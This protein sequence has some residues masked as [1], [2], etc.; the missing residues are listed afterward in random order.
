MN[1][2]ILGLLGICRRAGKLTLGNDA[3]CEDVENGKARLVLTANDVSQNTLKKLLSKCHRHNVRT[4][5]ILRTSQQISK[6]VGKFC[7]VAAVTD[8][9]FAGKLSQLIENDRQEENIYD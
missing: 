7:A 5:T 2:K 3:V 8:S 9:G 4:L 1:D 6:A